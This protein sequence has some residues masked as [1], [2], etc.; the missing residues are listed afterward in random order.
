[1][2]ITDLN[3]LI[4]SNEEKIQ[5]LNQKNSELENILS[6]NSNAFDDL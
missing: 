2:K 5:N 4:K 3:I 6:N 1:M